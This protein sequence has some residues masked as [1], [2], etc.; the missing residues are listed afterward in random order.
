M[1]Q[2][3]KGTLPQ[4]VRLTQSTVDRIDA[5]QE[6]HS[7]P[8]FS[9]TVETLIRMGLE[10]SPAEII[11]P[12]IVSTFRHEFS[13]QVERLVKLIVYDIIETGVAQRLAGAAVR[14]I[15]R[16][17]QDD[18]E[19]YDRIKAAAIADTRRRLARDNIGRV[20]EHLYT[21]LAGSAGEREDA[22]GEQMVRTD[23]DREGE[24]SV[25]R[26]AHGEDD[27]GRAAGGEVLHLS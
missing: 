17:K 22:S 26:E 18:P 14:D 5:Y 2:R 9:A 10:R 13:R 4:R 7:I 27:E 19:R 16:L 21:E 23:G 24:L 12:I 6:Q 15:G 8:S 11:A 20:I 3:R 1:A 25:G